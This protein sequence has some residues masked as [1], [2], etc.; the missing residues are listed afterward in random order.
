[1]WGYLGFM[2]EDDYEGSENNKL[3]RK[4]RKKF[5]IESS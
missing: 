3:S 5:Y 1:M 2:E 4:N